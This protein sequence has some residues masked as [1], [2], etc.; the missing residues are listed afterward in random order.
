MPEQLEPDRTAVKDR[1]DER[2]P[3]RCNQ[4]KDPS[5]IGEGRRKRKISGRSLRGER[6]FAAADLAGERHRIRSGGHDYDGL[7]YVSNV[8][9][10]ILDMF[11]LRSIDINMSDESAWVQAGASIGEE[12]DMGTM[13]R[14]YGLSVDNIVDAQVVDVKVTVFGIERTLEQGN[15][16]I[17]WK[18]QQV[19][20][21]LDEDL[22]IRLNL[23]PVSGSK[24]GKRLC[25][26]EMDR[27]CL[28][29]DAPPVK[30]FSR[31]SVAG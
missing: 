16:D 1:P 23:K 10:V 5:W 28:V 24:E 30:N 8:P 17:V 25:P 13:M 26:N 2:R 20:D 4:R 22:Y 29:L 7:S 6:T 21:K 3:Q 11:N 15:I 18:W 14:K 12:V 9:F 27:L 19:V 31:G